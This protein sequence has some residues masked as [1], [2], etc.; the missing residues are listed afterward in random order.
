M[1]VI[2]P[3]IFTPTHDKRNTYLV[4]IPDFKG[5]N[6]GS[7]EGYGLDDAIHMARD[8]IG[9]SLYSIDDSSLPK[10]SNV[11]SIDVKNS[12]FGTPDSFV[13]LVDLDLDAYRRMMNKKAVR[14]NVSIPEWLDE[15][16]KKSNLN[17]SRVLQEALIE[18]LG[19]STT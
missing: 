12:D 19:I 10:A 17:I 11:G 18:K 8:Y 9:C 6:A 7:T 2:Y 14:R 5:I 3:V 1:T 4:H 15:A 13:S 16:A